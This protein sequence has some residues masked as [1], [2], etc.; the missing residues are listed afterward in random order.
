MLAY[1]D[2]DEFRDLL[3]DAT[4]DLLIEIRHAY[5]GKR[6]YEF[7]LVHDAL[8]GFIV[9][10]LA[11]EGGVQTFAVMK[12]RGLDALTKLLMSLGLSDQLQYIP[13]KAQARPRKVWKIPTSTGRDYFEEVNLWL[14]RAQFYRVNFS[15]SQLMQY[16]R[17]L[18]VVCVDV[19]QA[20]DKRG[21]FGL[22][23]D[24]LQTV[25]NL[26]MMYDPEREWLKN[27]ELL[28]PPEVYNRWIELF[29]TD[30]DMY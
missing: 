28:N 20:L 5:A 12:N 17:T 6:I 27:A 29:Q 24:R 11:V 2:F 23:D 4:R 7:V 14:L 21:L 9:P 26:V 19:L 15:Y 16:H 8:W 13:E 3:L 25:V 10:K 1:L 18:S 22:D 30:G